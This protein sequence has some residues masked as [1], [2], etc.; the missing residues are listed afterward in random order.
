[1]VAD[2]VNLARTFKKMSDNMNHNNKKTKDKFI[3][4]FLPALAGFLISPANRL[5]VRISVHNKTIL[6]F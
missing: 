3:P 1:M 6:I 5:S 2:R 4:P